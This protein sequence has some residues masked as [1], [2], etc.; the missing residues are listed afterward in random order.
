MCETCGTKRKSLSVIPSVNFL[1]IGKMS[2]GVVN[3]S[4]I[5]NSM[6]GGNSVICSSGNENIGPSPKISEP[7]KAFV[8]M[9]GGDV[10]EIG[11]T[12]PCI[13][14][15]VPDVII[16]HIP[17]GMNGANGPPMPE[18]II[19]VEQPVIKESE[20]VLVPI[21]I[22]P[23]PELV[24]M[25][26]IE[27][28]EL[29]PSPKISQPVKAFVSMSGGDGVEIGPTGPCFAPKVPDVIITHIPIGM[30]G[31]NS[32]IHSPVVEEKKTIWSN[33]PKKE[34]PKITPRVSTSSMVRMGN[35]IITPKNN[36][37]M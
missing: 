4:Y 37:A 31:G 24:P 34:M 11:P 25:P 15:K 17:I 26:Y 1:P 36:V 6:N 30:N 20:R 16:T 33:M 21:V 32:V 22:Y 14:P 35:S 29:G 5:P 18:S 10:I 28:V 3:C 27:P 13:A 7:V 12:G 19:Q 2:I 23:E 8:S 9:S